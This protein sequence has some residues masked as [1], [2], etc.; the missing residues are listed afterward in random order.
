MQKTRIELLQRMP[1]FGG[2]RADALE[3][4][5]VHCRIVSIATNEFF[6]RE[7]EP[8]DSMFVIEKGEAEVLKSWHGEEYLLQTLREGD[9]VGEMAVMDHCPRSASVR[10]VGDCTA[11]QISAA[12]LHQ[13]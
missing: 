10:A 11:I 9:W 12:N 8:G 3:F 5:L 4:L 2:I 7:H 1:V 13:V 6:F